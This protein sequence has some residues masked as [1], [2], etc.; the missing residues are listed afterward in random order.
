[1]PDIGNLAVAVNSRKMNV[2]IGD[3][4]NEFNY[5]QDARM[6][7]S[8]TEDPEDTTSG[9]VVYFSGNNRYF[10][11]GSLLY[12]EGLY[13]ESIYGRI[14]IQNLL[15]RTNGE[16][17]ENVWLVRMTAKDGSSDT[18][19]FT[20]KLEQFEPNMTVPGGTKVDI[21][22]VIISDVTVS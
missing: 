15:E 20:C 8:H 4:T 7:F 1:M 6:G 13:D 12:T 22:L 11:E 9:G 17:A 2:F 3:L 10:L 18:F 14:S 21:R 16:V 19:S 5:L